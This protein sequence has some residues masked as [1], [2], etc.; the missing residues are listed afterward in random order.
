[1]LWEGGCRVWI[2]LI[3]GIM[4]VVCLLG[5]GFVRGWGGGQG[6]DGDFEDHAYVLLCGLCVTK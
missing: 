6:D 1:M 5:Y 4:H 2:W 3:M